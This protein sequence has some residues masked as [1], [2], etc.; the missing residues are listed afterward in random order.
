MLPMNTDMA[1]YVPSQLLY[2]H[3][4]LSDNVVAFGFGNGLIQLFDIRKQ[5]R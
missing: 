3:G 5:S 4:Y 2:S 1:A